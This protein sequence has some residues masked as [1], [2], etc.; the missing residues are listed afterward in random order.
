VERLSSG[1]RCDEERCMVEYKEQILARRRE[2]CE[3][4]RLTVVK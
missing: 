4:K 3:E 2:R 1:D